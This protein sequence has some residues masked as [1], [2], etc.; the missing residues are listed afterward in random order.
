MNSFKLV[1]HKWSIWNYLSAVGFEL[2]ISKHLAEGTNFA[3][4]VLGN[5]FWI[6]SDEFNKMMDEDYP[7]IANG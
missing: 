1:V 6:G 2:A 4:R 5:I 3:W 7:V